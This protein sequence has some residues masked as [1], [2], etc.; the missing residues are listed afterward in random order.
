MSFAARLA[1]SIFFPQFKTLGCDVDQAQ[2]P[3][4]LKKVSLAAGR[5]RSYDKAS[6]NLQDLAELE[7]A[8]KQVQ[9]V[10][11][12]IGNERL[13]EQEQRIERYQ[14]ATLP[15]QQHGQPHDAPQ[16]DWSGRAAVVQCD[17]GR[18]QIRDE[19]W[20]AEKPAGKRHRWWRETQS[21]VLQTYLSKPSAEDPH[22]EVPAELTDPL[23]A[24]P[25]FNE[26]HRAQASETSR[27]TPASDEGGD[28]RDT[29]AS[30]LGDGPPPR[31]PEDATA[32]PPTGTKKAG[33]KKP[34][35]PRWSGGPPLVKTVV[36]TRRG[37]DHLGLALAAEAYQRG[38]NK[39]T[40]KAF[41]GDGLKVNWSLWSRHFSH[42]TPIVDLMHALSYVYA[43]AVACGP[44]LEDGW[45]LYLRWLA[46]VWAGNVSRVIEALREIAAGRAERIE[47]VDRAITY[48][49][50]N[51]ARM[52][53][54]H[55]RRAGLPI[56]TALVE[57]TQKQINWRVKGTEKFWRDEHLEPLLQLVTDDLSDTH[58]C[59][60]FWHRRRK[61]FTGFRNRRAKA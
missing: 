55:Y 4:V 40:A 34:D 3:A 24:V 6:R 29:C 54:A 37:Y 49:S 20:D 30:D 15:E 59:Q 27:E 2:T 1:A 58:D 60:Q 25:K 51:A 22:P 28:G 8:P 35:L 18:A 52:N 33:D 31:E 10:A 12:R 7:V 16:N 9:R 53:Y 26:I 5:D 36:A 46:W 17:G 42:Y 43:A 38:F 50:N 14:A 13:E 56:T 32:S 21:G 47:A 44:T 41:L 11:I 19:L 48:L 23:W 57:S 45:S 61:R 39:A